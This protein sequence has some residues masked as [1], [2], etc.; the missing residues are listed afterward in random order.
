MNAAPYYF[1]TSE[2]C[3]LPAPYRVSAE[4]RRRRR[5]STASL[6]RNFSFRRKTYVTSVASPHSTEKF[7]PDLGRSR[8]LTNCWPS[9]P[10]RNR[11]RTPGRARGRVARHRAKKIE[12]VT[13]PAVTGFTPDRFLLPPAVMTTGPMVIVPMVIMP[14]VIMPMVIMPI[15]IVPIL[16]MPTIL[17]PH[18]CRL[19]GPLLGPVAAAVELFRSVSS[20]TSCSAFSGSCHRR[21]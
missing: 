7:C 17:A 2:S 10:A 9:R 13:S 14:M 20:S 5:T 19:L 12:S 3:G 16:I 18:R 11:A 4:I 15:V 8:Q 1:A 21:A 6:P